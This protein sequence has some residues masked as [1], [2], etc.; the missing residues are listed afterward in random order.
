MSA[1]WT[2]Q[3]TKDLVEYLKKQMQLVIPAPLW[4]HYEG[5]SRAV[6]Y[7]M[8]CL[9]ASLRPESEDVQM[10]FKGLCPE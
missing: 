3:D 4:R 2:A 8:V 10:A 6:F 1:K 5:T 9:H 7:E